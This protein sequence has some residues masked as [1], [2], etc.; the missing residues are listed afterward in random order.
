MNYKY[1]K[2][3]IVG[4]TFRKNGGG[5]I[6]MANLFK[7]WPKE[8]IGVITS[9]IGETDPTTGYRYY[10]LGS[11]E[12]KFPFPFG[13]IQKQVHSGEYIFKERTDEINLVERPGLL[14]YL[15]SIF[16]YYLDY[17]VSLIGLSYRFYSINVSASLANWIKAF[18]PDV[19]YIQPFL[20]RT[21]RFGN[22]LYNELRIPYVIHIMDDSVNY[23]N[24]SI[25]FRKL[26][27]KQIEQDFEQLVFNAKKCMCISDA[28]SNEYANRYHRSFMTFRNPVE[29]GKWLPFRKGS[30]IADSEVLKIIYTGRLFSPTLYSLI[31]FCQVVDRMNRKNQKIS[32]HIYTHD[33]N[34]TFFKKAQK[35]M[36]ISILDPLDFDEIPQLIPA[37]DIFLLCLDFDDLAK[38]YA[39]YSISTRTSEGMISGVPIFVYAPSYSALYK[40]FDKYEAGFIICEND[41][42]KIEESVM[43][44]WTD[45][46]LRIKL[47][48]NALNQVL[49]D[50]D[51]KVVRERF[52]Q[53]LIEVEQHGL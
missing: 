38:K 40:Y 16:R 5:G 2:V 12:I 20:H 49:E 44:L 31:D 10:Q 53:Y 1:P 17:A 24:K 35:M 7:E 27:Q 9:Q 43:K 39:Q 28:M 46:N 18:N 48:S 19:I 3:I 45:T 23:V 8:N 11:L 36:G 50:S 52:R 13:V 25:I 30:P 41:S 14:G 26:N 51:A 21:M 32:L 47:S 33:R 42:G 6:T 15:K 22:L 4:E 37:Y 34:E 29:L